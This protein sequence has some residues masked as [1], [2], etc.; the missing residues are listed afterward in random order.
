VVTLFDAA[1]E[2]HI[3][4]VESRTDFAETSSE[5]IL[6]EAGELARRMRKDKLVR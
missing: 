1:S 2:E 3:Y 6:G 4:S 5:I